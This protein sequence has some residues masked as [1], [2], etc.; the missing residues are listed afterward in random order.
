MYN[1]FLEYLLKNDPEK[2]ISKSGIILR[3][4]INPIIRKALPFTT[5]TK[6]KIVRKEEIPNIPVIFAATHGFQEDIIDTILIADRL[7]YILIGSLSQIFY[8]LD[9]IAAWVNGTILVDRMNDRSRKASKEK[10]IHALELG[11]SIII[12]PEGTWN[13]S[14]NQMVSGLFPGVYDVAMAT[15]A[16]IVP[17]A[18]H[19]EGKYVYGILDKYFDITKYGREEGI[20]I[21]RDK[22]ATLRW[23]LM[24]EKSFA[25]RS[26]FPYGEDTNDYWEEYINKLMS[27]VKFYDYEIELHTKFVDKKTVS[28]KE[29]FAFINDLQLTKNNAFLFGINLNKI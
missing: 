8:S 3:G 9:G 11:A 6:L 2:T 22:M 24:E 5:K 18:T 21:L 25:T 28:P 17:I 12:F 26:V 7:A 27:E 1:K 4:L 29:A 13:K 20:S 16:L 15:G 10:M 23:E 14:P 19:R